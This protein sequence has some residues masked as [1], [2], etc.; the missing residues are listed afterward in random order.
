MGVAYHV[1]LTLPKSQGHVVTGYIVISA[2]ALGMIGL[3]PNMNTL[4]ED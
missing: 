2:A 3:S 1:L 4:Q